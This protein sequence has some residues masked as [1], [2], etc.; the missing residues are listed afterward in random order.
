MFS[1][2]CFCYSDLRWIFLKLKLERRC[3]SCTMQSC[4]YLL[5]LTSRCREENIAYVAIASNPDPR[6]CSAKDCGNNICEELWLVEK[7]LY[8]LLLKV[9]KSVGLGTY[10]Y[11]FYLGLKCIVSAVLF[12]TWNNSGIWGCNYTGNCIL[13]AACIVSEIGVSAH[14]MVMDWFL[15][16]PFILDAMWF[17]FQPTV[18]LLSFLPLVPPLPILL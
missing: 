8:E 14:T 16:S 12:F 11:S 18:P 4:V 1:H 3:T 7:M 5:L 10:L 6:V 2:L 17:A 9:L 13:F 15:S